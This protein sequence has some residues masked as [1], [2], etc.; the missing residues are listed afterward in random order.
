MGTKQRAGLDTMW[1]RVRDWHTTAPNGRSSAH[2]AATLEPYLL[3]SET[4]SDPAL[5]DVLETWRANGLYVSLV[6]GERLG[7]VLGALTPF[8]QIDRLVVEPSGTWAAIGPTIEYPDDTPVMLDNGP[9]QLPRGNLRLLVRGW[10]EPVGVEAGK[11]LRAATH[12]EIVP[13]AVD[14]QALDRIGRPAISE[15]KIR[16]NA[17]I[18]RNPD[19]HGQVFD[20]LRL[21][22]LVKPG[23][24]LLITADDSTAY[25]AAP[26]EL[27]DIAAHIADDAV[28]DEQR[29]LTPWQIEQLRLGPRLVPWPEGVDAP[30]I[31]QRMLN[32]RIEHQLAPGADPANVFG[33]LTGLDRLRAIDRGIILIAPTGLELFGR[34]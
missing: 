24:A 2:V 27:A 6:P 18:R 11:G 29:E 19:R 21:E 1:W 14:T 13:Q 12:I 26:E 28:P 4:I 20:R 17:E 9:L 25:W 33:D 5:V 34:R 16:E 3:T 7:E 32:T 10:P 15:R 22:A 8:G 30:S 23:H 31:G